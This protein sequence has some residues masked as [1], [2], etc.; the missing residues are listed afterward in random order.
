MSFSFNVF[1]RL[2]HERASK[3]FALA[4]LMGQ[5]RG[6]SCMEGHALLALSSSIRP[7]KGPM[8]R[9]PVC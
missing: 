8:P 4:H 7:D 2:S 1:S 5:A 6:N 3:L 9:W